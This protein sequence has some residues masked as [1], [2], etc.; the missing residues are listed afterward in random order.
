MPKPIVC[1]SEQLCQ[2]LEAFRRCFSKRQWKYF[3]TVLLGL[4]ECEERKTMTGLLRVVGERISLSGLSRF[5][6]KWPWSVEE[7][8]QTWQARFR[9]RLQPLV[10]AEHER[11]RAE[12]PKAQRS[13]QANRRDRLLD[14]RRLRARSSRKGARWAVWAG[15]TRTPK[16][17]W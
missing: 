4:I 9:E 16:G 6:N 5:L 7:V 11:L 15:T 2:Y 12:R 1:L 13:S 3:V 14:L 17:G 10:Q 8:A